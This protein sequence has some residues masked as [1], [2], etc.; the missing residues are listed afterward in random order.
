MRLDV[1]VL[2][3]EQCL[4]AF[5]GQA[6]DLIDDL[7]AFVIARAGVA[8]GVLVSDERG[9]GFAHR[10]GDVVLRGDQAHLD[11]LAR[12]FF[13]EQR[14]ELRIGGVEQGENRRDLL[15]DL[16]H[17]DLQRVEA[18]RSGMPLGHPGC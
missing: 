4:G 7:L 17:G 3:A 9:A 5:D 18:G 13:A 14:G 12:F 6:L 1:D 16:L 2:G 8:F 10:A 11:A 15:R